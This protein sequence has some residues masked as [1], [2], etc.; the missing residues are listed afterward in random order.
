[1]NLRSWHFIMVKD[2]YTLEKLGAIPE[3]GPYI[4]QAAMA[5]AVVIEKSR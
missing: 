2:R 3:Y 1:M 5:V 4:A